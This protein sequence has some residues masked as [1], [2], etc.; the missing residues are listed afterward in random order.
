LLQDLQFT[1]RI[2]HHSRLYLLLSGSA[3]QGK[4][5]TAFKQ[6]FYVDANKL[7]LQSVP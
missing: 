3:V 7:W 6:S 4:K 5:L 1:N 2:G